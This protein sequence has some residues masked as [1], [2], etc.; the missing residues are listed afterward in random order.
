MQIKKWKNLKNLLTF[1]F[2]CDILKMPRAKNKFKG[3]V[4]HVQS[5]GH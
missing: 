1:I 5:Q 2:F 3:V 4:S